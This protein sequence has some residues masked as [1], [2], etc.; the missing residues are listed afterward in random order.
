LADGHLIFNVTTG[1]IAVV[2][3]YQLRSLVDTLSP[4]LSI[5]DDDYAMKL[6]L[7]HT[8][9]NVVGVLAV[10][11]FLRPMVRF[12]GSLFQQGEMGRGHAKYLTDE[13]LEIPA[14]ALAALRKETIHLYD[15]GLEAIVHAMNL[16]RKDIYSEKQAA[17]IIEEA[18]RPIKIDVDK[19][20]ANEIKHLYGEILHYASTSQAN[21][22]EEDNLEVY[23]LKITARKIIEMVKDV[24]ELQK[25]IQRYGPKK[26]PVMME[27][28]NQ[29]RKQLI[30]VLKE[31]Q[32]VRD[33]EGEE[34][35]IFTKLQTIKETMAENETLSNF[36]VDQLIRSN[37]IDH[38]MGS[39][40]INDVGFTYSICR[41]LLESA[42]MLW[43]QD[44]QLKQ[45]GDA[46]EH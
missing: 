25:N 8:I 16:H 24:R 21:M 20:Y 37:K 42:T 38:S 11:P 15:K 36:E 9:F 27:Q 18:R 33:Y 3:I 44:S 46:Y 10:T 7:F 32:Y 28:Y 26:N 5:Q 12:L 22:S 34:E 29:L 43:V 17:E 1:L 30:E 31:I 39:S 2:F 41:K 19:V 6:A 13:V 45:L 23:D 4:Y 40:L 35:D 14:T